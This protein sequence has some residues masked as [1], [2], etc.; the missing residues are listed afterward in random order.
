MRE[1]LLIVLAIVE[2]MLWAFM[3]LLVVRI[4]FSWFRVERW[5]QPA[6][7][8]YLIT[9]PV[10]N[11]VDRARFLRFGVLDFS[12]IL[13]FLTLWLLLDFLIPWLR[14]LVSGMN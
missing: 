3:L 10:M 12:P 14:Y 13:A 2:V 5:H 7:L 9:D 1:A 11:L 6:Q 4:V 8:V